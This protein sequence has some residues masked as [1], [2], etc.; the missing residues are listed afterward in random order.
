MEI[1]IVELTY[2]FVIA[3]SI[4]DVLCLLSYNVKLLKLLV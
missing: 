1:V 2:F 4:V 3:L